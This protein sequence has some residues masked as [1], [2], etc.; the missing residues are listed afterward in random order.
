MHRAK[1]ITYKFLIN[2]LLRLPDAFYAILFAVVFPIYKAL[3]KKRAYGRVEKH[4]A[5]AKEYVIR[6]SDDTN[7][8]P[9]N[10]KSPNPDALATINARDTFK[11][12][13]W[14]ALES[15]RANR[16][17]KRTHHSRCHRRLCKN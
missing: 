3:H 15:Y 9:H 16:V 7:K 8:M 1:V 5:A 2:I 17:R 6:K 14:N 11:G 4:L 13:F 12:I 10:V